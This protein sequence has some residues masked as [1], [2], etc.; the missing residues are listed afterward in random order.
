MSYIFL[1]AKVDK[2]KNKSF[3][4]IKNHKHY[5]KPIGGIWFSEYT[6]NKEFVSSW[7]KFNIKEGLYI[8]DVTGEGIV[9]D[10]DPCAKIYRI[11]SYE[12]ALSLCQRFG[13]RSKDS[14]LGKW[15]NWEKV[16]SK[17]DGVYLSASGIA[18]GALRL[19]GSWDIE[20]GVLFKI[21]Y[22]INQKKI[23]ITNC[24]SSF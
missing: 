22:I 11:D 16:A 23:D 14:F 24:Q 18:N 12:D 13:D 17:Y 5:P 2:I 3:R 9:F 20:S 19:M 10:V 7:Q 1:R 4:P 15:I 8:E 21:K 6:P